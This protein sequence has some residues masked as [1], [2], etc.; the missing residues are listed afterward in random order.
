MT[1]YA[2][3]SGAAVNL[4]H[5][6]IGPSLLPV[7]FLAGYIPVGHVQRE[8]CSVM[9]EILEF[10]MGSHVADRAV[11]VLNAGSKLA[12]MRVLGRVATV[13]RFGC[14]GKLRRLSSRVAIGALDFYVSSVKLEL[15]RGVIE[16]PHD[17]PLFGHVT[18]LASQIRPMRIRMT[19]VARLGGEMEL[20][21]RA[22]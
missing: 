2:L 10:P 8:S 7:A 22:R 15:G 11:F 6:A 21:E 4:H 5:F 13:A 12:A 14:H 16:S 9:P 1:L 17:F 19:S 18:A 3:R 20:A